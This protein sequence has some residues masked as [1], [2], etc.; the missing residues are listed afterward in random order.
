MRYGKGAYKFYFAQGFE[1][2]DWDRNNV[3]LDKKYQ[4]VYVWFGHV[5]PRTYVQQIMFLL[6]SSVGYALGC[7]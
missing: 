4:V 5:S 3:V 1:Q 7:D 6:Q 2:F